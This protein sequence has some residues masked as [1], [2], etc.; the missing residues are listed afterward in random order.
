MKYLIRAV[1]YFV[2]LCVL[3]AAVIVV[4]NLLGL[5]ASSPETVFAMLFH[6]TRGWILIGL[7]VVLTL[8]YPRMGYTTL[9]VE[10]NA[11]LDSVRLADAM[12]EVGF[13]PAGGTHG[14]RFFRA[15][16]PV[17]RLL[18][19]FDRITTAQQ[20]SCI[21]IE[22]PRSVLARLEL[23]LKRHLDRSHENA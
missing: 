7:V 5:G 15:A 1:K 6:T 9:R 10:G 20:G 16:N 18:L 3:I 19:R 21:E 17:R 13:E 8:L 12:R 23:P 2:W 22:G 14:V 4:L 11:T